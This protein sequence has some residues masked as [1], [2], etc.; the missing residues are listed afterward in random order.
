M[1]DAVDRGITVTEIAS[2]DQP[3]DVCPA[4][5]A[6]FV[7]RTLRG[8]LHTP[9]LVRNFAEFRRRFGAIWPRSSLGPAVKQFFEHGGSE[10]YIVRVANNARGALLCLPASGS[11]LVLRA[12]EPGST[13]RVRA[14]VDYDRIDSDNDELFNLTLQRIDPAS[15]LVVEQEIFPRLSHV[16]DNE[17]F[18]ADALLNSQIARVEKPYPKHRPETTT[19]GG[20]RYDLTWVEAVQPGTDGTEL[21]DYDL[22]GSKRHGTGLFALE[23]LAQFDLL[24]LPSPGKDRD[25]GPPAI[26]AA[27]MYCRERGAMLVVDPAREWLNARDAVRGIRKQGMTSPNLLTYFPRLFERGSMVAVP[28]QEPLAQAAGG[29]LAGML[30]KLDYSF[31]PWA[32]PGA[33]VAIFKSAL[34]PFTELSDDEAYMLAR[35]GINAIVR[36]SGRRAALSGFV[37]MARGSESHRVFRSLSVRRLCL[38]IVNTVDLATRWVV[39]K[40]PDS[41]LTVRIRG[42]ILAYLSALCEM[43]ALANDR[44]VVQCDAGLA[45]RSDPYLRGV[46]LLLVFHPLGSPAPV[47]FTLHQT[48]RGCQVASTAFAPV[49]ERCA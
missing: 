15:G 7:G 19:D 32:K 30:C 41:K 37:T 42:Q 20:N 31:G 46:T 8:P 49:A 25:T 21:T 40:Q 48:V 16:A 38:R 34:T 44:F 26:L 2:I 24:Y 36:N 11:A 22:I 18:V 35:A 1:S 39:F 3:I 33:E 45:N 12:A 14:S 6:A 47:S 17:T 5:T 27:E 28:A 13:E 23:Q 4:T 9:V 10:L 29:A 43:G